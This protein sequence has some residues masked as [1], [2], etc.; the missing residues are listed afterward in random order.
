MQTTEPKVPRIAQQCVNPP[1]V[2]NSQAHTSTL[3][4]QHTCMHAL[5]CMHWP[6]RLVLG[7][8]DFGSGSGWGLL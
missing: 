1:Q 8:L 5:A 4:G 7:R 3:V 2:S 6:W